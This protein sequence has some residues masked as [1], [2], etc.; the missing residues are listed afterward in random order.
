MTDQVA[1]QLDAAQPEAFEITMFDNQEEASEAIENREI[2]GALV[3]GQQ[4]EVL[5]ASSA[6]PAIAQLLTA[7]GD[8]VLAG[9][10]AKQGMQ[11]PEL[12]VTDLAPLPEADERGSVLGSSSLPIVIGGIS[13]GALVALRV[14]NFWAQLSAVGTTSLV[15]GATLA[16]TMGDVLGI[17]TGDLFTNALVLASVLGAFG[18]ALVGAY[19]LVGLPGFGLTAATFF[20]LGNPL[21]GISIPVEFYPSIWGQVGQMMPLGAGFDL[22]KKVNFFEA[23]DTTNSWWVLGTW[24]I[25]GL[26]LWVIRGIRTRESNGTK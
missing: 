18:A 20:L 21:S 1:E 3:I 9:N 4:F 12:T 26:M 2:Y 25:A 14:R 5:I 19:R 11:V 17:L 22:L 16:W 23:A 6:N 24:I 10:L 8:S 13:L 7:L 15:S